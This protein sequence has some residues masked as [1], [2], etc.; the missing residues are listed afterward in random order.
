MVESIN[1]LIDLLE[2]NKYGTL[3]I[4]TGILII[5]FY[6]RVLAKIIEKLT[7]K[8]IGIETYISN[9]KAIQKEAEKL[10]KIKEDDMKDMEQRIRALEVRKIK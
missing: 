3:I 7:D 8:I 2:K 1:L 6:M 5:L 4:I 9:E 10:E